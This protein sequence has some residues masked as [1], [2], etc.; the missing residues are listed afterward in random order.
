MSPWLRQCLLA[1]GFVLAYAA[2]CV[3]AGSIVGP[4]QVALYW[5]ASGLAF[6]VV[7]V[8]GLRWA[9]LVPI[10]LWLQAP[11]TAPTS[12]AFLL[13]SMSSN[14]LALLAGGWLARRCTGLC[15]GTVL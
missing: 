2:A 8:G 4:S 13:M 10:A 11:F 1:A 3:F 15:P 6:A 7:V 14:V 12:H 5:P 9:L